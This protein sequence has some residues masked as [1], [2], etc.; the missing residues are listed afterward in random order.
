[1]KRLLLLLTLVLAQPAAADM[2][3]QFYKER[4]DAANSMV[5]V[6]LRAK[7]AGDIDQLCLEIGT[8]AR[9]IGV[10]MTGMNKH[11]PAED[12]FAYRQKLRGIHEKYECVQRGH[13]AP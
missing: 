8:A 13:I 1:M 9:V 7:N 4:I 3:K 5:S 10:Y 6:A 11:F 12:W 2:G